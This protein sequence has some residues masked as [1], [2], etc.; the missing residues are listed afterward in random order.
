MVLSPSRCVHALLL[1]QAA[2]F[3]RGVPGGVQV[4]RAAD[5]KKAPRD[6]PKFVE[7]NSSWFHLVAVRRCEPVLEHW[8]C[9]FQP[10]LP[11]V[12]ITVD[13]MTVMTMMT[14]ANLSCLFEVQAPRTA[15][16]STPHIESEFRMCQLSTDAT[17]R[18]MLVYIQRQLV[19]TFR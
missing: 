11:L 18:T 16:A 3:V 17:L 8:G 12:D 6:K 13:V 9:C 4:F 5:G 19:E 1:Q 15:A 10:T 7:I 14:E 2:L